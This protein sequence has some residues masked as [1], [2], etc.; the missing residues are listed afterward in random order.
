MGRIFDCFKP[1]YNGFGIAPLV[2]LCFFSD[3][4]VHKFK[5]V[6]ANYSYFQLSRVNKPTFGIILEIYF[7][8]F[9]GHKDFALVEFFYSIVEFMLSCDS[10]C[11]FVDVV[12]ES[13]IRFFVQ[14]C[15]VVLQ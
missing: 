10:F 7:V 11:F 6:F 12:N 8:I 2:H 3:F 1:F 14:F 5:I 15:D 9:K 13:D 4:I